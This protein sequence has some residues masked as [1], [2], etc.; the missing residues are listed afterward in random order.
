MQSLKNP[1]RR[2]KE[3]AIAAQKNAQIGALTPI[4]AWLRIAGH[5]DVDLF[6]WSRIQL[7]RI[8]N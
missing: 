5:G 1:G 8:F 2:L 6:L 7:R 3:S 4:R